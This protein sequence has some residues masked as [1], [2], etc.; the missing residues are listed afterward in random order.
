MIVFILT[1]LH[2]L[3]QVW[4]LDSIFPSQQNSSSWK[5]QGWRGF[6]AQTVSSRLLLWAAV[7]PYRIQ[8]WMRIGWSIY[9]QYSQHFDSYL[10]NINS[11]GR[12]PTNPNHIVTSL[13]GKIHH[14]NLESLS[15][16]DDI[17]TVASEI[18]L[19][20]RFHPTLEGYLAVLGSPG[21]TVTV[22]RTLGPALI[23]D[24]LL[25]CKLWCF[26]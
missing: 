12:S 13:G 9:S 11:Y 18:V 17:T 8:L 2:V 7:S 10:Y 23:T 20:T 22:Q 15:S 19:K 24:P 14:W 21:P 3:F 16:P 26:P 25:V 6:S 1:S 5:N 4:L